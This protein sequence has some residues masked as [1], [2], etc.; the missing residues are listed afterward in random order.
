MGITSLFEFDWHV[1]SSPS[2]DMSGLAAMVGGCKMV[3]L[4]KVKLLGS[5]TGCGGSPV[6]W[7]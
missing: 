2:Q 5:A 4:I 6:L 7:D 1:P 3:R